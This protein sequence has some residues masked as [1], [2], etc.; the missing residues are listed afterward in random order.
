MS[1][2]VLAEP[3]PDLVDRT[4]GQS[5]GR[6]ALLV[7]GARRGEGTLVLFH[8]TPEATWSNLPISGTFVEML[9]RIVQIS[10]NQGTATTATEAAPQS[11]A[12]YRLIAANGTLEPPTP[13]AKPLRIG[14]PVPPVTIEPARALRLRGRRAGA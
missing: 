4:L 2:Q 11:L 8:V 12:P 7:T 1:R 14:G 5:G 9:R 3:T 10:R 13:D 6:L